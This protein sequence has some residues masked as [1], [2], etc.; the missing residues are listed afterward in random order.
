MATPRT[1]N[2]LAARVAKDANAQRRQLEKAAELIRAAGGQ[3]VLP[4]AW[5]KSGTHDEQIEIKNGDTW[6]LDRY[7]HK[8][9]AAWFT[10]D[11]AVRRQSHLM[12]SYGITTRLAAPARN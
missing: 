11:A 8:T 3:A 4:Y 10:F 12:N 1:P 9:D 5:E 7:G 6:T 2:T